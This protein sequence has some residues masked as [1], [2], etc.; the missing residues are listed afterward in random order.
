VQITEAKWFEIFILLAIMGTCI[1]LAVYTPLP[2]GDTN[3]TNEFMED[4]EVT[5][6]EEF[7]LQN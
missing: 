5:H 4:I 1:S 6:L 7:N 3:A 2:N